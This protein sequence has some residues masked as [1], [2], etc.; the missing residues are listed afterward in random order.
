MDS[1]KYLG[2]IINRKL[3][4]GDQ[5]NMSISKATKMLNLLRRNLRNYSLKAKKRAYLSLVRPHLEFSVPVWSP[6]L[7]KDLLALEKV[8]KRAARWMC[9]QWNKQNYTWSKSYNEC[10]NELQWT[11]LDQRRDILTCCQVYKIVNHLVCIPFNRYFSFSS[12]TS[13]SHNLKLS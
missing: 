11:T 10:C 2:V 9:A 3:K 4:W 6:Y 1:F 7:K 5:I 8:Q 13:H 12:C